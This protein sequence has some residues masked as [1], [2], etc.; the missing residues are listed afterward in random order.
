MFQW[1]G[2]KQLESPAD[3]YRQLAEHFL[4]DFPTKVTNSIFCREKIFPLES[5]SRKWESSFDKGAEIFLTKRRDTFV[6]GSKKIRR[7]TLVKMSQK[8]SFGPA[9]FFF[10]QP[11]RN[12]SDKASI[13]IL[14]LSKKNG[15]VYVLEII[16]SLKCSYG[17]VEC[18]FNKP[19]KKVDMMPKTS[20]QCLKM[21]KNFLC[22]PKQ[23]FF[24]KLT[25]DT[26][27][28][29]LNSRP[30]FYRS[31]ARNDP[32]KVNKRCKN[33][34]KFFSSNCSHGEVESSL[35]APLTFFS[36]ATWTFSA[37]YSKK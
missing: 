6:Q 24:K 20:A 37:R 15:K 36:T 27:N 32:K 33:F 30:N 29:V 13:K 22:F 7:T 19:A 26:E 17:H 11:R 25:I 5:F 12:F 16:S 1:R 21:I 31:N 18:S 8:V 3:F 10:W 35:K 2:R 23:F 34:S 9:N 28:A 4:L 14:L